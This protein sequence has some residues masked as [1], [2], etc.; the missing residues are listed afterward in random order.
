MLRI[1][2]ASCAEATICG[3]SGSWEKQKQ[4]LAMGRVGGRQE[5]KAPRDPSTSQ[6]YRKGPAWL[7]ALEN[8]QNKIRQSRSYSNNVEILTASG[9]VF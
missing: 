3:H 6:E 4:A 8:C 7:I 5:S 1:A 2:I 9:I